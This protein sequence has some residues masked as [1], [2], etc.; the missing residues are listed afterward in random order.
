MKNTTPATQSEQRAA[1]ALL[2]KVTAPRPAPAAFC[3]VAC[4]FM[5]SAGA[6]LRE[7][8]ARFSFDAKDEKTAREVVA[9]VLC[10]GYTVKSALYVTEARGF[11]PVVLQAPETDDAAEKSPRNRARLV[12]G[13][14]APFY[15]RTDT[16]APCDLA[17]FKEETG[18]IA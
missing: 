10:L 7:L 18:A 14:S 17:T 2:S 11:V 15:T 5:E 12:M 16:G 9:A 4:A 3:Y 13:R 8:P 6:P 1:L